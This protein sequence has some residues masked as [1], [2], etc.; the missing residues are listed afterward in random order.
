[1]VFPLAWLS[2]ELVFEPVFLYFS[3]AMDWFQLLTW[4]EPAQMWSCRIKIQLNHGTQ[5]SHSNQHFA[6][7]FLE[8]L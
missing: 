3:G 2:S 7:I 5:D 8:K 1:M 4:A 6:E